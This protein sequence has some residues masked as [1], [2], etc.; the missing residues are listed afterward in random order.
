[1]TA[2]KA[3]GRAAT[4]EALAAAKHLP[5]DWLRQDLGLEDIPGGGIRIPVYDAAGTYLYSRERDV[6][7]GPRF[8]APA[9]VRPVPYG[10][11][12]LSHHRC[13]DLLYLCEGES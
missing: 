1:M 10:R 12:R 9:G 8:R 4:V 6:P 3:N 5:A 11:W 2:A 7:G 13:R